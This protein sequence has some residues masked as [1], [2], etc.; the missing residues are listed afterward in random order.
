MKSFWKF[1]IYFLIIKVSCNLTYR[2]LD[3]FQYS[4]KNTSVGWII[5]KFAIDIGLFLLIATIF[6]V[7][8]EKLKKMRISRPK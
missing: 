4:I 2:Q 3:F 1:I 5:V 6:F 8:I 7:L